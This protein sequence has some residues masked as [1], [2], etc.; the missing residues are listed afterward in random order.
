MKKIIG[1]FIFVLL[2]G[3]AVASAS[4]P[5]WPEVRTRQE[6]EKLAQQVSAWDEA[7]YQQGKSLVS[8]A[9]YDSLLETLTVWRGCVKSGQPV[10]LGAAGRLPH[11][12]AHTGLKKLRDKQSVALWIRGRHDLWAQPKVDGVAVTLIY[13][14]GR[15]EKMLSRGDG[16]KG[17]DWTYKATG[18]AAIPRRVPASLS[19]GVLQG[20]LFLK[21]SGHIQ[22]DMGGVNARAKV[23]GEM[24]RIGP[25]TDS[26]AWG[27]FIWA[28]PGGPENMIEKTELLKQAGFSLTAAWTKP[29]SSIGEIAHLRDSW[30][31]QPL[32]FVTDGIVIRQ[33]R[34]P[35]AKFWRPGEGE[36]AVA[37]KFAPAEQVAA[38]RK[39]HFTVGRTGKV[40][41]VLELEETQLDD[42]RVRRVNIGSV[43]RWQEWDVVAGDRVKISLAGQG[44]PRLEEVVWRV[45]LRDKPKPPGA[46]A[47][48]VGCLFASVECHEQFL[49][50]L[51]WLSQKSLLDLPGVS[52]S[53]W[54]QLLT[55]V[56]LQHIFSW[57]E[58]SREALL[59][60][61]GLTAKKSELLW[62]R[63]SLARQQPFIRWVKAM[64]MPLPASALDEIKE[65]SW[66]QLLS[67]DEAS[68]R[69][70]P[71]VGATR[72]RQLIDFMKHPQVA[73]L[74]IF[75]GQQ[76]IDGFSPQ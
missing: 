16:R 9:V 74:V 49:A 40:A 42:K 36:W 4:C 17:E 1:A 67:R 44:I 5:A 25:I 35:L 12:V 41:V 68:W 72:A 70:L 22:S 56:R 65:K 20:E 53:G 50:R 28:W 55:G 39:V 69:R 57:L 26:N 19:N 45:G 75:L 76:K 52:Q 8:D 21:R 51:I 11:P 38:V 3:Q 63:F 30:Y 33:A 46:Q 43:K 14:N 31:R 34:E 48:T 7:Y 27:V 71:G 6:I 29:V 23:A 24:L 64:G 32:P 60:L 10:R 2:A 59:G 15:L 13:R 62:H 47:S 58:L 18:I 37:W 73:A 54:R 66:Q 61:P